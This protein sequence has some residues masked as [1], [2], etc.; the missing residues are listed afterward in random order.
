MGFPAPL[1]PEVQ[2]ERMALYM[3]G[4]TDAEMSAALSVTFNTVIYWRRRK[5]L[6]TNGRGNAPAI[7]PDEEARRQLFHSLGW[8]AHHIARECG[9]KAPTILDWQKKRRL[10]PNFTHGVNER[11]NPRPTIADLVAK[12]RRSV[13]RW[14]PRD[15]AEDAVADL[16][17]DVMTGQL[18]ID[19]IGD[20]AKKYGNRVVAAF[21]NKWG[22]RSLDMEIG[23]NDGFTLMDTIADDNASSWLEEMG[24]TVW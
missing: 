17:L 24:A 7:S 23:D 21:A 4:K 6:P 11:R 10:K 5:G 18:A 22:D 20:A 16:M 19:K 14:L 9:V 2:A 3:A 12:C 8:S 15:I 13:A 1:T